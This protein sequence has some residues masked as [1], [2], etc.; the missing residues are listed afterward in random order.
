MGSS[1][2]RS[3]PARPPRGRHFLAPRFA[4]EL[5]RGFDV[6]RGDLVVEVGAGTGRLT[7]QLARAAGLVLAIE[8]D[9]EL[10][11]GLARSASSWPNVYVH[12]GDALET[13]FPTSPYR[14]VGNVPFG[15]TTALLRRLTDDVNL[16]RLDLILQLEPARKRAA[17]RGSV[18]SVL[19][20]T[21]WRFEVRR[22]IPARAF[23]PSPTVD[24]AWLVGQRRAQPLVDRSERR[25]FEQFV[26]RG[27][28]HA[29]SPLT[30]SV[31]I[32][33]SA[34]LAVGL[35]PRVRALDLSVDDWVSIWQAERGG[36]SR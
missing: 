9:P 11:R 4:A 27:F 22:H 30:R 18:L 33:R 24:A 3:G 31:G 19:W 2:S 35:S 21:S 5:V 7:R 6:R 16:E 12:E 28:A 13:A 10:A 34:V 14:V 20:A 8:L 17:G 36:E 23:H 15:I 1:R 26:R 32:A 25:S 29:A